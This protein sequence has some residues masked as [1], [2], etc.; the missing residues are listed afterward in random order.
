MTW[1]R[2]PLC[3][4]L[5]A[6]AGL[7]LAYELMNGGLAE[8]DP[9]VITV[10][11]E[12]L[13]THLQFKARAFDRERFERELAGVD[14][15]TLAALVADYTREEALYREAKALQLDSNDYVARLRLIQ[16][17]EFTLQGFVDQEIVVNDEDVAAHWNSH[18]HAYSQPAAV[19]FTHVFFSRSRHGDERAL[20]LAQQ[21]GERLNR[22]GTA[23]EKAGTVGD[24][25]PYHLN[26]IE[27]SSDIVA[28]HFGDDLTQ[29]LFALDPDPVR[30]RG[31]IAS[32]H[33]YHLVLLTRQRSAYQPSLDEVR[34]Q[35]VMDTRQ[36]LIKS[37][38]DALKQDIVDDYRVET[39]VVAQLNGREK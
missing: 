6:G 19:T 38:I 3:H 10:D 29:K 1:W 9:R 30:W 11:R 13:L 20:E 15:E 24:R 21:A 12:Q 37:R 5:I 4:F 36:A 16:Q 35:V 32:T 22:E 17:L 2:D 33:G 39:P 8:E 23:F 18:R 26:Y 31:P 34:K 27:R 25:F 28:S 7:F 14:S